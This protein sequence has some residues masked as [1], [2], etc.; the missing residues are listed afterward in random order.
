MPDAM[1]PL[2]LIGPLLLLLAIAV[3]S[4][5]HARASGLDRGASA[6]ELA[7]WLETLR[8]PVADGTDPFEPE[9]AAVS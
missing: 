3:G 7:E 1:F 8:Q 4:L 2:L 5:L 9:R 6:A